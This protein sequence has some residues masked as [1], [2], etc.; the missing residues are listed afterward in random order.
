MTLYMSYI[1]LLHITTETY[2]IQII[3][4]EGM[5]LDMVDMKICNIDENVLQCR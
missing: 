3:S 1:T 5:K 4:F 2:K